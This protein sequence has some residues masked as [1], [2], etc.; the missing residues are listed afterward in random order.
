[1]ID[2]CYNSHGG[3]GYIQVKRDHKIQIKK[4]SGKIQLL[5]EEYDFEES[6]TYG[7][8]KE[9]MMGR[10]SADL[11]YSQLENIRHIGFEVTDACNLKCTYCIYG[12]FYDAYDKRTNK[13]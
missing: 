6:N 8:S 12:D 13:K 1:M 9:Y 2:Y 7:G 3:D 10:M 11:V 5:K 4:E